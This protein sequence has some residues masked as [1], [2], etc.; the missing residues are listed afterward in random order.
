MIS[1]SQTVNRKS[2]TRVFSS[3]P[4]SLTSPAVRGRIPQ[5]SAP[6]RDGF[7]HNGMTY[8]TA[9]FRLEPSTPVSEIAY[10]NR[11]AVNESTKPEEVDITLAVMREMVRRGQVMH[12]CEPMEKSYSVTNWCG[13]WK[14]IDWSKAAKRGENEA[15]ESEK[16]D[17]LILGQGG[18]L[19]TPR[20]CKFH[21]HIEGTKKL[22]QCQ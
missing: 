20:R 21:I 5:L 6:E 3:Q 4:F 15:D 9:R 12:T 19:K 2:L 7:I 10:L 18:E 1:L 13:A 22:T 8:A 11:K 16:M 17:I 14:G